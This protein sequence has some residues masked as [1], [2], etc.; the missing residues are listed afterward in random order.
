MSFDN[1]Q[2]CWWYTALEGALCRGLSY[3]HMS[4]QVTVNMLGGCT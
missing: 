3:V 1:V 4:R 2:Y